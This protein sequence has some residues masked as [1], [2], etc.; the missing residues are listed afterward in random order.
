VDTLEAAGLQHV[1]RFLPDDERPYTYIFEGRTQTLDHILVSPALFD[2]LALVEVLHTNA[3]Y[4]LGDPEDSSINRVSDHDP[5]V[6]I[7]NF[8]E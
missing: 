4:P 5:L 7:F 8:S 1:Y 6:A 3:D 2:Q